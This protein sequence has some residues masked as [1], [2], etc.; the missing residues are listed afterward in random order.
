MPRTLFVVTA[1]VPASP[2]TQGPRRDYWALAAGLGAE[3]LDRPAARSHWL[4]GIVAKL[5]GIAAAQAVVAFLRRGDY[6]AILTDG[7]HIGIPLAL[8]LKVTGSRMPHVTIG[9]RITAS[10]RRTR[11]HRSTSKLDCVADGWPDTAPA[12]Q[13][14]RIPRT[15]HLHA[16]LLCSPR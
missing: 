14:Q 5:F 16:R 1:D 4:G 9:H 2:P 12:I 7:E 10:L 8:L 6:D 15:T 11:L 3:M 13:N